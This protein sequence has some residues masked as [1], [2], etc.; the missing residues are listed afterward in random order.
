MCALVLGSVGQ[1]P[2]WGD[3]PHGHSSSFPSA[4]SLT[5]DGEARTQVS[6]PMAQYRFADGANGEFVTDAAGFISAVCWRGNSTEML[7]AN[8]QGQIRVL[9]L[10]E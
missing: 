9:R 7:A 8:S 6:K 5:R 3:P 10:S 4:H 1:R 2:L